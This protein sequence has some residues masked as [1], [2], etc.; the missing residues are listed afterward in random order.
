MSNRCRTE[1]LCYLRSTH[2]FSLNASGPEA[3]TLRENYT[4]P[5]SQYHHYRR[6]GSLRRLVI[7]SRYTDFLKWGCSC[8]PQGRISTTCDVSMTKNDR[9]MNIFYY[10]FPQ[11]YPVKEKHFSEWVQERSVYQT[12]IDFMPLNLSPKMATT[13]SVQAH[14]TQPHIGTDCVFIHWPI[15]TWLRSIISNNSKPEE[16]GDMYILYDVLPQKIVVATRLVF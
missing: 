6:T 12:S 3:G 11:I 13:W 14:L 2:S 8:L 10:I 16:H 4:M 7:S 5:L 9:N 1:N 15:T